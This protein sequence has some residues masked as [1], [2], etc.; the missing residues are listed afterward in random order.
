MGVRVRVRS[1]LLDGADLDLIE[2]LRDVQ[3]VLLLLGVRVGLGLG[4]GL[5]DVLAMF[6]LLGVR[7]GVTRV[8][9]HPYTGEL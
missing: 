8:G 9:R 3:V 1:H 6:L 2:H 5:R 4:L 7:V